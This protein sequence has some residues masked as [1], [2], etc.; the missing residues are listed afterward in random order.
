MDVMLLAADLSRVYGWELT[1]A[2]GEHPASLTEHEL[3]NLL[4]EKI[5]I[6][7]QRDF[8][9]L[10]QLLYRIDVS[11]NRLRGM[12]DDNKGEDAGRLIAR[13]IMER[14]WQKIETRRRYRQDDAAGAGDEERW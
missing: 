8:G 9:A 11:E 1:A 12:L 14:Q 6:L 13:L 2:G 5:N 10:V 4:A 7:I 3:E